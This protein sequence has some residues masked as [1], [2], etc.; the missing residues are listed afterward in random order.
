LPSIVEA[1]KV[2][3]DFLLSPLPLETNRSP[4]DMAD[5]G[6]SRNIEDEQISSLSQATLPSIAKAFKAIEDF[7]VLPLPPETNSSLHDVV[8][9]WTSPNDG[10]TP[11]L[12]ISQSWVPMRL[13][14]LSLLLGR[15]I[16]MLLGQVEMMFPMPSLVVQKAL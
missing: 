2:K 11:P 10:S 14:R 16:L 1:L 15:A 3:E 7:L 12:L 13:G 6:K 8:N 5:L 9:H 4:G